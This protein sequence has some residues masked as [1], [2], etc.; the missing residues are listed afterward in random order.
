MHGSFAEGHFA[1]RNSAE[2]HFSE[3]SSGERRYTQWTF[4]RQDSLATGHLADQTVSG[5]KNWPLE[6]SLFMNSL[7]NSVFLTR[8]KL[9]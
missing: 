1:D 3:R 4:C 6:I 5:T 2:R 7:E 8:H 9:G